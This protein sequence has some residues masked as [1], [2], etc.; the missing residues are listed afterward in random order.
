MCEIFEKFVDKFSELMLTRKVTV[1]DWW[2]LLEY[3]LT[4][5]VRCESFERAFTPSY[6]TIGT[7]KGRFGLF[8]IGD[9]WYPNV[10][11]L[12]VL[13]VKQKRVNFQRKTAFFEKN[14]VF[15]KGVSCLAFR[16]NYSKL[17][18]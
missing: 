12:L 16:H 15:I 11:L 4:Y 13:L 5:N 10:I 9:S 3:T 2:G 18:K 14:T 6:L 1:I 17:N 8:S 7:C